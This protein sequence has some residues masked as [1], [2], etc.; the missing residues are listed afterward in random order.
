[1][2]WWRGVAIAFT[3]RLLVLKCLCFFML[4]AI[5]SDLSHLSFV[6][7]FVRSF[8]ARCLVL[9]SRRLVELERDVPMADILGLEKTEDI[10][11]LRMEELNNDR[12]LG[13]FKKMGFHDMR[14]R[15]ENI[16]KSKV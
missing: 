10:T 13:F 11:T 9:H 14:R 8:G 15:V 2:I 3:I 7:I 1:M 5:A 4:G 16:I 6:Y 12:L